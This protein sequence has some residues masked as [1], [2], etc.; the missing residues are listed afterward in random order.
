MF[1][2]QNLV[3]KWLDIQAWQFELDTK[4]LVNIINTGFKHKQ[5]M[6][7]RDKEV[8]RALLSM[9]TNDLSED[10]SRELP[11]LLNCLMTCSIA[12][13]NGNFL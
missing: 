2:I 5:R 1:F 4:A 3:N 12:F 7:C 11:Q 13:E 6:K 9:S 8:P 10:A